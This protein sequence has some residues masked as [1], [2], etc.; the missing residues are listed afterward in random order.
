MGRR[1]ENLNRGIPSPVAD[2]L[3][4][5]LARIPLNGKVAEKMIN[6]NAAKKKNA[7]VNFSVHLKGPPGNH[8]SEAHLLN[9]RD[10]QAAKLK[11]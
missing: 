4:H 5:Y 10:E 1:F 9:S 7:A 8:S 2:S 11:V 6:I 3:N